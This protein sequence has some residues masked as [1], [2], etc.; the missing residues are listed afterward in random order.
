MGLAAVY[1]IIKSH[2]GFLAVQSELGKGSVFKI[3][4]K[5]YE[6]ITEEFSKNNEVVGIHVFSIENEIAYCRNFAPLFGK[7][8]ESANGILNYGL[9]NYLE[10]NTLIH[11]KQLRLFT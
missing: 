2:S 6:S 3:L 4:L 8:E 5:L 7:N 10:K 1:G 9:L 11:V